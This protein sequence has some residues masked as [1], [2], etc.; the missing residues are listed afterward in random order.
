MNEPPLVRYMIVCEDA[1]LEGQNARRLNIYGLLLRWRSPTS[2]FPQIC[3]QLCIFLVLSNGRGTGTGVIS[4]IHE[5][6]GLVCWRATQTLRFGNDPL[7]FRG[8]YFRVKNAIFPV[9]GAYTLEFRYN[10]AVLAAQTLKVEG[11]PL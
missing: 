1:R 11:R 8:A 4:A 10:D 5:E 2:T 7:A 3:P 6:T 9:P